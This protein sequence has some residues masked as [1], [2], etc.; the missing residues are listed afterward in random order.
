MQSAQKWQ[1]FQAMSKDDDA[2]T[3][4]HQVTDITWSEER[5]A[6]VYSLQEVS[7]SSQNASF[8]WTHQNGAGAKCPKV[9]STNSP[10][11]RRALS[12][13]RVGRV[14][15]REG[16]SLFFFCPVEGCLPVRKRIGQGMHMSLS[17]G[18]RDIMPVGG[19]GGR[20]EERQQRRDG[21]IPSSF[22]IWI[23][24]QIEYGDGVFCW[25]KAKAVQCLV[26]CAV[27]PACLPAPGEPH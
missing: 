4:T 18:D 7:S 13:G 16:G 5:Q 24:I 21:D 10:A 1:S 22:S 23:S 11:W 25:R 12:S 8:H 20:H 2:R 3:T 27:P 19:A 6:E 15:G 17:N 14:A 9:L 26:L